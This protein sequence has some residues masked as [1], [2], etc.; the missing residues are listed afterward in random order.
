MTKRDEQRLKGVL[1]QLAE[2][3]RRIADAMNTL[4]VPIFVVEGVRTVERQRD[5]Y[6][7]GRT[8]PGKIVTQ[9]DGVHVKSKHQPR[10]DG[11]G[12]AV[13]FAFVDDPKTPNDETWD[14]KQPWRLAGEMAEFLGLVWGGR[15]DFGDFGHIEIKL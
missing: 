13:D 15:W 11:Y 9:V 10:E 7:Q 14:L 4:G 2:A 8:T 12:Y 6:A 3:Y 5:L 1:P